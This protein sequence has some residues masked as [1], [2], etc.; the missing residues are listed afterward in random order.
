M[1]VVMDGADCCHLDTDLVGRVCF[2]Q[3]LLI[4]TSHFE[5]LRRAVA[6]TKELSQSRRDSDLGQSV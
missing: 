2:G 3:S 4:V 1:S 5:I 6:A